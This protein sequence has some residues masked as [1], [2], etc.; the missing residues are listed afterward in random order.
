MIG[1]VCKFSNVHRLIVDKC[2]KCFD[3]AIQFDANSSITMVEIFNE[4]LKIIFSKFNKHLSSF[5]AEICKSV[6]LLGI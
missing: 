4:I 1:F 6:F 5:L 3:E 2:M